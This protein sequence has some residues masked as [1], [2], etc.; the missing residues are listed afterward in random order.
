MIE[1]GRKSILDEDKLLQYYISNV[2]NFA[3]L[4]KFLDFRVIK[5]RL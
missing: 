5:E 4:G 3:L 1:M 2:D